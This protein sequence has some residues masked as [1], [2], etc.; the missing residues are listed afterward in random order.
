MDVFSV[1]EQASVYTSSRFELASQAIVVVSL[2]F[3]NDYGGVGGDR[4][5]YLRGI[6]IAQQPLSR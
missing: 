1:G 5:L 2:S 6:W 3:T 4:N